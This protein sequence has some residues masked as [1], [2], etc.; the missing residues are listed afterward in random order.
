MGGGSWE[1]A[2]YQ[3]MKC[4]VFGKTGQVAV[5]LQ[6]TILANEQTH[7]LSRAEADL[8]EPESCADAIRKFRPEIVVNTAAYTAVDRAEEEASLAYRVNAEAPAAMAEAAK[9]IGAPFLHIS[10]DYVFDGSGDQPFRPSDPTGPLGVYGASKLAGERAIAETG[11]NW[12]VLRTSWVF[13]GHGASFVKT[14]IRLGSERERLKVVDDQVGGPTPAKAIAEAL[15]CCAKAMRD[16]QQG[17]IYHLAGTPM[18]SW[19][20]FAREIMGAA[21][22]D[23]EIDAI[24]TSDYP[25]Q[26]KR[27]G[28]SR[29]DCSSFER[30]FGIAPPDWR[31]YLSGSIL[32]LLK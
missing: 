25:T 13:S 2:R 10:T 26:A 17:G 15:A 6:R 1:K 27:P 5:E 23:C 11:A 3:G 30:D 7:F 31:A 9:E 22:L 28:N 21:K 19:A 20:D 24:P 8:A 18:V 12:L 32:E 16:G 29:L 4:L 14:M